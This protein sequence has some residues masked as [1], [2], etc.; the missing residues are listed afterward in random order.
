VAHSDKGLRW[1]AVT[2]DNADEAKSALDRITIPQ[3]V[4]DRIA[5]T[6]LPRSSIIISDDDNRIIVVPGANQ[7]VTPEWIIAHEEQI[8]KSDVL[9]LQLEIP[10]KSVVKA[11]QI[12]R[13]H[14]VLVLLNPA[15]Y[16][17][18]PAELIEGVTYFTPN[19]HEFEQLLKEVSQEDMAILQEK[20]IVTKGEEGVEFFQD[21]QKT[22]INAL[23]VDVVDTTG[24]GDTFNGAL[25]VALS[26]KFPLKEAVIFASLAGSLSVTKLGA[27]TGMP[28][29]KEVEEIY[30]LQV[31]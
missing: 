27:Q 4:L 25:A 29:L 3:D 14:N 15:P 21:N 8:R 26:R 2:I 1:T 17:K 20:S 10:L 23:K 19:E 5:P 7:E 28:S 31:K 30:N 16:Q 6:A 9:L 18:L 24:A 13:K 22:T 12:A 11:T